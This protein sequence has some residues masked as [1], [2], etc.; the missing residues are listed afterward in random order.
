MLKR[1]NKTF[2]RNLDIKF[3]FR[4]IEDIAPKPSLKAI[5]K[6]C[7]VNESV[8]TAENTPLKTE[9]FNDCIVKKIKRVRFALDNKSLG[10]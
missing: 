4:T 7:A 6:Q 2:G 1:A 9:K 10:N 3:K 8:D 5:L